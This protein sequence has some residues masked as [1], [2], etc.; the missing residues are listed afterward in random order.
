MQE[1]NFNVTG[2]ERKKLVGAI[3][4]ILNTPMNYLGVPTFSYSIGDYTIDKNGTVGG[5]FNGAV[6]KV[7]LKKRKQG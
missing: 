4:E 6:T 3:S 1:F 7:S 5:E 2:T